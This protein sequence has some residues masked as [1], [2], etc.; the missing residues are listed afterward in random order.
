MDKFDT[1]LERWNYKLYWNE[2]K[3][4]LSV[5]KGGVGVYESLQELTDEE[6]ERCLND[7]NYLNDLVEQIRNS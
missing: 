6:A 4:L 5:V 2:G 7:P 3:A 1:K